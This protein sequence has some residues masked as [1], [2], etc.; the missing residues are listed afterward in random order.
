MEKQQVKRICRQ[1]YNWGWERFLQKRTVSRLDKIISNN[2]EKEE[3]NPMYYVINCKELPPQ[4]LFGYINLYIAMIWYA[5][6]NNMIPIID[7][8]NYINTYLEEDE[9]GKVNSW[10][11]FFEPVS[12]KSLEEVY[13]SGRYI[14]GNHMDID[15]KYYPGI[16]GY[17]S[18]KMFS[19]FSL[20]YSNFVVFSPKAEAYCIKEARE[21]LK[22]K[23]NETLGVLI[24][25]TD[26]RKAKGH[27][28]QPT[29]EEICLKIDKTLR[30]D[31]KFKYIYLAT[32][33]KT[34]EDYLRKRY[35]DMILVNKRT[36]YDNYDYSKGLSLVV[37]ENKRDRFSRGL[38]YL[39]SIFILSQC[40]GL[41]S[42]QCGGGLG[43]FYLNGGKYRTV[44][45]WEIGTVE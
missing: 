3:C 22:G 9:V 19:L 32:E 25:G 35:G 44:Y 6:E 11:L 31:R 43:A 29:L 2:R 23:E 20:L 39:S 17:H 8:Q 12:R 38:E 21:I 5:I 1:I 14:V 41:L 10:E 16:N 27:A 42:G 37:T 45:F 26:I 40:G 28:I 30:K 4:G 7:M 33:E 36:Y 15:W 18:S 34:N 24:R 13:S